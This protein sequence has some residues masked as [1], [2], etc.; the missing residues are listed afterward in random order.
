MYRA[1]HGFILFFDITDRVSFSNVKQWLQMVDRY[2]REKVV[3][4]IVA[5]KHDLKVDRAV[6]E[7]Q[8]NV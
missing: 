7:A 8:V 2:S 1:A 3:K 4:M 6:P 5:T